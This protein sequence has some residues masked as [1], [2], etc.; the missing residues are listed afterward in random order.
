M[1]A[2]HIEALL[3]A[4]FDTGGAGIRDWRWNNDDPVGTAVEITYGFM[5]SAPSYGYGGG[6]TGFSV[7][8]ADQRTAAANVLGFYAEISKITFTAGPD[9]E[10]QQIGFGNNEQ[11]GGASG[12]G[13]FPELL[14]DPDGGLGG[15]V[16]INSDDESTLDLA[17]GEHGL[18]TLIHE[19]GHAL[20]LEHPGNYAGGQAPHLDA[21]V[22]TT[23]YS[24]M[25]YNMHSRSL[26]REVTD[27]GGGFSIN[28]YS[29]E[30]STPMLYDI[31]AIQYLYGANMTTRSGNTV[32]AF[33]PDE[34]FLMCIWDG[35]GTDTI[36]VSNFSTSCTIN[37]NAG[38]FSS[39]AILPDPYPGG[40]D[41]N[42][43][44]IYNGSNNLS[45]A[46]GVT[47]ENATGGSGADRLIGNGVANTLTGSN[48]ND[49]LEGGG[50]NDR[51]N[52]GGGNDRLIG[53]SGE[54]T[55]T[56]TSS[57]TR[58]DGGAGIA[59]VL[60]LSSGSLDIT[61]KVVNI[62]IVDLR[63]GGKQILTLDKAD[64]LAISST[65][66]LRVLGDPED[67]VN[68]SGNQ[69]SAKSGGAGFKK[70]SVGSGGLLFVETDVIVT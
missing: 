1:A 16:W 18:A 70:Y 11:G 56:C 10:G 54:D 66:Q 34:P 9:G 44:E 5:S 36:T 7:F 39:I 29:I 67:K 52:G 15:D 30:P 55:L 25:S 43:S 27:T 57:D 61:S 63:G 51:L 31:A 23:Q 37:L 3:P 35:G 45:I 58:I 64:L 8:D 62:E 49:T 2:S 40:T 65:D 20:G 59:D 17:A 42:A 68:F 38:A 12:Y 46:F 28:W 33:Q 53:G 69:G 24:A 48:G 13:F 22:D 21:A 4:P 14:S 6:G 19:I 47:I 26:W 41:P 50:G 60:D 32:Y